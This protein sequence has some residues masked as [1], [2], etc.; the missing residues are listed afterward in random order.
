LSHIF[1]TIMSGADDGKVFE[2]EKT[3]IM[4]GRHEK[5][6]VYLPFDKRVSRHHARITNEKDTYF[7][8]DVGP[9]G[10]GSTNKTYIIE[11]KAAKP[12]PAGTI[13]PLA[14]GA[15]LKLGPVWLK[16]ECKDDIEKLQKDAKDI[17]NQFEEAG[18]RLSQ[19]EFEKLLN[20]IIKKLQKAKKAIE[21]EELVNVMN[22]MRNEI[23]KAQKTPPPEPIRICPTEVNDQ[24]I[25]SIKNELILLEKRFKKHK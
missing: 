7:I 19:A 23:S 16:F 17:H 5:D 12:I 2:F 21:V 18:K 15:I 20:N 3:P 13:T 11:D 24:D 25:H 14:S 1:I 22:E 4:L 9:E 6:D 8:E 10:E